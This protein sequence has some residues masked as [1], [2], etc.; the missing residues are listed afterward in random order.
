ML[1]RIFPP[2]L[3]SSAV[4]FGACTSESEDTSL[5]EEGSQ[6]ELIETESSAGETAE[7]ATIG[8][9]LAEDAKES[10]ASATTTEAP[11]AETKGTAETK[12]SSPEQKK[13]AKGNTAP[14]S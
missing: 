1:N 10:S 2:F 6:I 5:P 13:S 9:N 3:I 4:V 8:K 12:V 7:D 11:A 14:R